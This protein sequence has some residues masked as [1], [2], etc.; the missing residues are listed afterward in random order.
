MKGSIRASLLLLTAFV[1]LPALVAGQDMRLVTG[2]VANASTS[3]PMAGV[4]ITVK[5]MTVGTVSSGNGR[6]TINVPADATTLVFT[7]L[8]YKTVEATITE[9]LLEVSLELDGHRSGRHCRHRPG[10]S[11]GETQPGLLRPA[12]HGR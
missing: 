4:Q 2:T 1:A 11:E 10:R 12:G 7:N 5:G 6:F 9:G 8:G 3:Q